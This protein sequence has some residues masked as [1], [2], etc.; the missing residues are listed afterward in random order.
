MTA[1]P[2][3]RVALIVVDGAGLA[4]AAPGNGVRPDTLP[5]LFDA[6]RRTG[7][8]ALAASGPAVGIEAGQ[9]GNSEVGHLTI[10]L[11]R[12]APSALARVDAAFRDGSWA[13]SPLWPAIAAAGRL[14]VVGLVSDAGVHGHLRSIVQAATVARG[15]G[16]SEIVVHALLDG[17]DSV[18]GSGAALLADL[19]AALAPIGGVRLGVV[20]GR[21]WFC[22]RTGDLS[23]TRVFG[24]AVAADPATLPT[25]TDAALAAHLARRPSEADFPAHLAEGGATIAPGE[26]VIH[27]S[28]R[29]DRA[30]QA[31]RLLGERGPVHALVTLGDAVPEDRTFFPTRPHDDGLAF[32]LRDHAIGS[33][34]IAESCKFPHV[35]FFI[36]GFNG[37]M[38]ETRIEIPSPPDP[39]EDR[40]EM[41]A[42]AVTDAICAAFADPAARV[43]IANIA[44]LDQVGHLGRID[45]IERAAAAVEAALARIAASA[46]EHGWTVLLT[47]D[48]GNADRVVDGDGRPFGSHT[49]AAVPF[50]ALPA[51]GTSLTWRAG[52]GT[53]AAVA[54]SML[55]I[56]GLA[57]PEGMARPILVPATRAAAAE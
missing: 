7:H 2:R 17:T 40:P 9:V 36:N 3:P 37:P 51:P 42:E 45:L 35:T 15:A 19:R 31:A 22:D 57:V 23:A 34:R 6:M 44:N 50:T 21:K 11:G 13:A 29:A 41:A 30:V 49:D 55:A 4:P 16:V 32:V 48:H 47:A 20:M 10:G 56:L 39:L 14:H 26:P 53:L 5:T 25:F 38:G 12:P 8:A 28:H 27:A 52:Q 1:E 54:P 18:A 46:R 33:T 24:D 43:V